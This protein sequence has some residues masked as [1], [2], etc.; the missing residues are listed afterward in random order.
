MLEII[1]ADYKGEF[2]ITVEFNNHT[3]ADVNLREFI[4][5][6]PIKPFRKLQDREL[7]K[8]FSVDY[9]IKWDGEL[10]IAPEYLYYEAFKNDESLKEQFIEWGYAS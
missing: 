3:K 4:Q 8:K 6:T 2:V 9:T 5:T 10:D 1:K 7:F